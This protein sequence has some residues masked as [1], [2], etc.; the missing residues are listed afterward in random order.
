[1]ERDGLAMP[2]AG[3]THPLEA[4]ARALEAAG[5]VIECLREP[6]AP[7][8]KPDAAHWSRIPQFLHLR[9]ARGPGAR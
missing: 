5:L 6:A 7:P 8:V 4:Y 1:M 2:F 3:R 9:A